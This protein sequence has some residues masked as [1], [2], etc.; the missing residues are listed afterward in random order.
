MTPLASDHGAAVEV[1]LLVFLLRKHHGGEK[2]DAHHCLAAERPLDQGVHDED[3]RDDGEEDAV[4]VHFWQVGRRVIDA[5]LPLSFPDV[6]KLVFIKL[7]RG[8]YLIPGLFIPTHG[9]FRQGNASRYGDEIVT[10]QYLSASP[11]AP[12]A[13]QW[14]C[15]KK[16]TLAS[17]NTLASHGPN[18]KL[19]ALAWSAY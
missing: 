17:C 4:D 19:A 16:L 14:L 5:L 11:L 8:Q 15:Q 2:E 6:I 10:R 7:G 1:A 12:G 13:L 18:C 3:D 9:F